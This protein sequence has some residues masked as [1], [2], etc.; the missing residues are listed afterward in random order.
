VIR[1]QYL[2]GENSPRSFPWQAFFSSRHLFDRINEIHIGT[3]VRFV[4]L[5]SKNTLSHQGAVYFP[6][7]GKLSPLLKY[8]HLK[9]PEGWGDAA[10][11]TIFLTQ[12]E[13]SRPGR[14]GAGTRTFWMV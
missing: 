10:Q 7:S 2:H 8:I 4:I 11:A 12:E 13:R 14:E 3:R 5:I 1:L 9:G 6:V